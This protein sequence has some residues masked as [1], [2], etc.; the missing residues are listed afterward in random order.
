VA[1]TGTARAKERELPRSATITIHN[2]VPKPAGEVEVSPDNGRIHFKNT[3]KKSYRLRFS[4]EH[5]EPGSGI[6]ILLPANG[7]ITVLIKREDDWSYTLFHVGDVM[8][9]IGGGIIRN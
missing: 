3:D 5:S 4:K 2:H 8:N 6:D 9:G 7:T 1:T